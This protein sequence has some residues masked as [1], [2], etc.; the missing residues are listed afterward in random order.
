ME[1]CLGGKGNAEQESSKKM[2]LENNGEATRVRK[3][4]HQKKKKKKKNRDRIDAVATVTEI[5]KVCS[6]EGINKAVHG[7]EEAYEK[8]K[9]KD[10]KQK[11]EKV[12]GNVADDIAATSSAADKKG[13]AW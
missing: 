5:E 2:I 7:K 12:N 3:D 13:T 11:L 6:P 9:K 8:R 1:T 4:K 10:K